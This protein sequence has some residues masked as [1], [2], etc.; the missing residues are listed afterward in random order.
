MPHL[1]PSPASSCQRYRGSALL[2]SGARRVL[3]VLP[4]VIG[5][6]GLTAWAMGWW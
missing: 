5:L 6:W 3:L 1:P 4:C 2:H